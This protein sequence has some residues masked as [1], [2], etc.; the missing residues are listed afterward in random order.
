[1][2]LGVV[3]GLGI[4]VVLA[5][6]C[7]C[8][9]ATR[10]G[11]DPVADRGLAATTVRVGQFSVPSATAGAAPRAMPL[12]RAAEPAA[13]TVRI[14]RWTPERGR[15]IARR[16]LAWVGWP[17]SFGGGNA[18]GPTYGFAV[19]EASR[20]DGRIRGFDCSGLVL[21]ALAPWLR[22]EHFA[23]T[24]YLQAGTV[25]PS[26][27]ELMPGDLVFWS[28]DGTVGGV[29]HVAVYIGGGKVVQAPQ[30]GQL[31]TVTPLDRV[32]AGRIGTTR[33]LT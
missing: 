26:L 25:H 11:A 29:G 18:A 16:A 5:V 22:V 15:L 9:A 2:P 19:D 17:Y 10:L 6:A 23:A 30:S 12:Q 21:F 8:L 24:Q 1:M 27:A 13:A 31:I 7:A 4:V 14:G 3:G 32:E 28:S 20:N 33:P